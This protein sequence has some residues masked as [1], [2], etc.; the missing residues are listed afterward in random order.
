MERITPASPL[1][2]AIDIGGTFTDIVLFD[3]ETRSLWHTK[4]PTTPADLSIGFIEGIAKVLQIAGAPWGRIGKVTHGTT[5]AT[6][7][8]LEKKG[9]SVVLLTTAGFRHVLEIGRH[10]IPRKSNFYVWEKP[11]RPVAPENVIEIA[12]MLDHHGN[13]LVQLG[14]SGIREVARTLRERGVEGIA[15]CFL[16]SYCNPEHELSAKRIILEEW[17]DAVI[18]LSSEVLPLFREYERSMATILNATVMPAVSRYMERLEGHLAK[19]GIAAPL[20]VMKSNGGVTGSGV[21]RRQPVQTALSG[22]AA[23]V[24]GA[25]LIGQLAGFSNVINVD[26]GGTSADI[27][28]IKGGVPNVTMKG[29][30]GEWP[31]HLPMIDI[32]TIGAGGGSIAR[33][34]EIDGLRVGPESAGAVPGP[35]CYGRGGVEPTVTD[36]HLVLGHLPPSLLNGSIRLDVEV[37]RRAIQSKIAEPLGID[38]YEAARGILAIVDNA[39]VG[40]IRVVSVERGHDPRDFALLPTG[41]AGPLHGASLGRLLGSR[42]IVVPPAPGVLCALGLL[43]SDLKAEYVRTLLQKPN[44]YDL[45]QIKQVYGEMESEADDWLSAE[46]IPSHDRRI[47]RFVSLRYLHQGSEVTVP[48]PCGVADGQAAQAAIASFHEEHERL[49]GFAQMDMLVEMV[50]FHVRASGMLEPPTLPR[51]TGGVPLQEALRSTTTI[52]LEDGARDCPVY[53]RSVI[54]QGTEIP[55][56]AILTQLDTTILVMPGQLAT[57]DDYGSL[58]IRETA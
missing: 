34:S 11:A 57:V 46:G 9:A 6:N 52:H 20:L 28:L 44:S 31:L 39:M 7:L 36:A 45:D 30:V 35:V 55:G 18:S 14:E 19:S 48:W 26:I 24:I 1:S 29:K 4:T 21:I 27:S 5:V 50:T 13:E 12:G 22:P 33:V 23:G 47:E 8:I 54:R 17:P 43:V 53:E 40:A 38:L 41:G 51:S 25:R 10:D 15:V 49:Y 16:H 37:A 2:V 58:I 56:P 3:A 32:N 42:T